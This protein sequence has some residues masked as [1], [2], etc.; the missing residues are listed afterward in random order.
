M[1]KLAELT[2]TQLIFPYDL[3]KGIKTNAIDGRYSF[4]QAIKLMLSGTVLSASRGPRG[5]I[6]VSLDTIPSQAG[7]LAEMT[8]KGNP[9]QASQTPLLSEER[10]Y[11]EEITVT[12]RKRLESIR[13][14][15]FSIAAKTSSAI[16]LSG[17]QDL[18]DLARGVSGLSFI[19]LGPGQSQIAI[20]G[21]SAGQVVR[22]QPGVK[23]QVGIY[24]DESVISMALF[25]PDL[26]LFDFNRIEVLRGP[27][28]TLYG[29]GSLSGTLR[30]ISNMPDLT[31]TQLITELS[32]EYTQRGDGTH[33]LKAML[34]LPVMDDKMAVRLVGYHNGLAGYVD[35]RLPD[36]RTLKNINQG[37]KSGGRL[38]LSIKPT[39]NIMITPRLVM[40]KIETD[41]FP[42]ADIYNVLANPFTQTRPPITLNDHTQFI[43]F[44]ESL[45]DT[46]LMTDMLTTLDMQAV[47]LTAVTTYINRDITVIRDS[48]QLTHS[49]LAQPDAFGLSGVILDQK[50]PLVD[51]TALKQT[52][53]ELRLNSAADGPLS[54]VLGAFYSKTDRE[55]GQTLQVD[56]FEDLTGLSTAGYTGLRDLMYYARYDFDFSQWAIF[57]EATYALTPKVNLSGGL[58]WFHFRESRHLRLDGLFTVSTGPAGL[59]A[60]TVSHGFTPR[61]IVEYKASENLSLNAQ[62]AKGFRLGGINDPLNRPLC[63]DE[64]FNTFTNHD[65]FQNEELWNYE[66]GLKSSFKQGKI[67]FDAALFYGEVKNLQATIDAGSCSSRVIFNVPRARSMGMEAEITLRP[68]PDWDLNLSASLQDATIRSTL[69]TP[70][71]AAQGIL[72]GV[73]ARN[74]LP[75]SPRVQ[76]S[77]Q[78]T[79]YWTLKPTWN[80]FLALNISYVGASYTQIRD[81][82][83]TFGAIDLTRVNLGAPSIEQFTFDP[84][85]PG[86][87]LSNIRVGV[88]HNNFELSF[89]VNNLWNKTVRTSLDRERGGIARIGYTL[90]PPRR[91]GLTLRSHF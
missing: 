46:F 64:D 3:V 32:A 7:A 62:I 34:N 30:Y 47:T 65:L 44:R 10:T 67:V 48:G 61:F 71:A 63:T 23:E 37:Q 50:A 28:G 4:S 38:A 90:S 39:E 31:K 9:P 1:V 54:Y 87:S 45:D 13:D 91:I 24:L 70:T 20:R 68:H 51:K 74:R 42:R 19:D 86:Y 72:N 41:G 77:A 79:H 2:G 58:R 52:S 40:Q 53:Q 55:Y 57:G 27:Q 88:R 60:K 85:L 33:R 59:P 83:P 17:S 12:A 36:G 73:E 89:Y 66:I 16:F 76:A 69:T 81:Q 6:T 14:V 18:T 80:G 56:G 75:T 35:A 26:D 22:D 49:I 84:Q 82:V 8:M 15:P 5:L 43:Q 25:T 11:L 29:S 21:I 78:I